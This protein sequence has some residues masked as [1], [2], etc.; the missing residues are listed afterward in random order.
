MLSLFVLYT[1]VK[2]GL[3]L[4]RKG[5][6]QSALLIQLNPPCVLSMLNGNDGLQRITMQDGHAELTQKGSLLAMLVLI[7]KPHTVLVQ[8][9]SCEAQHTTWAVVAPGFASY[10]E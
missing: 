3:K 1:F 4:S 7:V 8:G 9:L 10:V 2:Q 5:K 6:V